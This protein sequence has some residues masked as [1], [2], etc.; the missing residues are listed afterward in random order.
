M[1]ADIAAQW[2][3]R[4]V[5]AGTLEQRLETIA[6][7]APE[8][9]ECPT[10]DN[11]CLVLERD[12]PGAAEGLLRQFLAATPGHAGASVALGHH[13]LQRRREDGES[14]LGQ[15]LHGQDDDWIPAA[16][17]IPSTITRNLATKRACAVLRQA[18]P[19]CRRFGRVAA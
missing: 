10:W 14:L 18:G 13:W 9:P 11:V 17:Q 12:G 16:G 4:H 7:A 2:H 6:A 3:A 19:V 15:V 5:R 1:Q 8:G